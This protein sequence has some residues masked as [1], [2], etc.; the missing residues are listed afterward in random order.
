MEIFL[1][2]TGPREERLLWSRANG[3]ASCKEERPQQKLERME[4]SRQWQGGAYGGGCEWRRLHIVIGVQ[5]KKGQIE[6]KHRE[7]KGCVRNNKQLNV[8]GV[9]SVMQ[10]VGEE[11]AGVVDRGQTSEHLACSGQ[12]LQPQHLAIQFRVHKN[13]SF[14]S[15]TL[16]K[17]LGISGEQE[18]KAA[19]PLEPSVAG[20]TD[21]VVS[22]M[23]GGVGVACKLSEGPKETSLK[24]QFLS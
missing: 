6:Q 23:K 2:V 7:V 5:N 9:L 11:K 10:R 24:I 4:L 1:A 18:G 14:S 15:S 20:E 12:E 3:K 21:N 19:A 22:M 13:H 16:F 8:T 17:A